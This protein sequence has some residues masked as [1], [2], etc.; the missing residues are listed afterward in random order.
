MPHLLRVQQLLLIAVCLSSFKSQQSLQ[1]G[2]LDTACGGAA[3]LALR[4]GGVGPGGARA[5][6]GLSRAAINISSGSTRSRFNSCIRCSSRCSSSSNRV[7][8]P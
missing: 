3:A 6:A 7:A 2:D 4:P 8:A 1:D 5:G